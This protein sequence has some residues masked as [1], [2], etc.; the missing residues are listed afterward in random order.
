MRKPM[1]LPSEF[2]VKVTGKGYSRISQN[3]DLI[4]NMAKFNYATLNVV[5][6]GQRRLIFI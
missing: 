1:R 6:K 5:L 3:V 2:G 4:F